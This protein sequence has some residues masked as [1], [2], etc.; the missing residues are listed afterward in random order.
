MSV[1]QSVINKDI[2]KKIRVVVV[3]GIRTHY[4]KINAIQKEY[5]KLPLELQ[6]Q[7]EVIYVNVGQ[8]YDYALTCHIEALGVHF[9]YTLQH[10]SKASY[11]ILSSIFKQFG[12]LLDDIS[13]SGKIDY[14]VVMGDVATTAVS[15]MVAIVKA[16]KVVHIEGGV[17][18]K[19]GNGNEE[20][21]R[22]IAD[23]CSTLCFASTHEDYTNLIKEA[24]S[25]RAYFSGDIMYDFVKDYFKNKSFTEFN[26]I[27]GNKLKSYK[28]TNNS[29]I[30]SSLHHVEN[31][32]VDLLQ[33][34]FNAFFQS[35]FDSIFIAHPRIKKLIADN[36]IDTQKTLVVDAIPYQE[37][38][39]AIKSSVFCF[40]DSGGIQREAYYFNKRCIV[41]SDLTVW[42]S[43]IKTGSNI[44]IG[45]TME[46]VNR[47]LR[48]AEENANANY[49]YDGCFGD[50]Q[51]VKTIFGKILEHYETI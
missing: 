47:G 21:Y 31:I 18:V 22:T 3:G 15:A 6:N 34:L 35:Q 27:I 12:N 37:N 2:A 45:K 30:L 23:H 5:A 26:Y 11:D 28:I 14:V 50:G 33:N 1:V 16:I 46:E 39:K 13:Q 51:A 25:T 17:R 20:F 19:R 36:R 38:L 24:F 10:E 42:D 29:Y 40:T 7:F 44:T 32:E 43:I 49:E 41:C 48:W 8:H 4:I 9:D